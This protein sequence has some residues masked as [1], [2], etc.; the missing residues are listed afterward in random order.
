MG[1]KGQRLDDIILTVFVKE[2]L[3]SPGSANNTLFYTMT[4]VIKY[5]KYVKPLGFL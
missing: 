2:P 1:G 3:A 5:G 4:G